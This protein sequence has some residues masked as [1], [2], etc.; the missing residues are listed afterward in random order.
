MVEKKI[1][2]GWAFSKDEKEKAD[3]NS[4]IYNE[5]K[6]K[7]RINR[8]DF[9]INSP[10]DKEF[11]FADYDVVIGRSEGQAIIIPFTGFIKTPQAYPP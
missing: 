5:L 4:Q 11:S 3:R 10:N 6:G 8:S 2:S 9:N 1:Y 7:Y